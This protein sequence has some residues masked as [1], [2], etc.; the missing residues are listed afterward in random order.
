MRKIIETVVA[1]TVMAANMFVVA[2]NFAFAGDPA[3]RLAPVEV[4]TSPN[5][6][7]YFSL[8]QV[9][10]T[11]VTVSNVTDVRSEALLKRVPGS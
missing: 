1:G 6:R 10:A 4:A 11:P 9:P 2:N 8:Q 7:A 3:K 5:S